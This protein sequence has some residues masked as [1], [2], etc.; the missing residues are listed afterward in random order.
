MI[1]L[2]KQSK[3]IYAYVFLLSLCVTLLAR[4]FSINANEE[5][6][7]IVRECPLE[8]AKARTLFT[9]ITN[10]RAD[11]NIERGPAS[12]ECIEKAPLEI[13]KMKER[14]WDTGVI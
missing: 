4:M 7:I 10:V 1:T 3:N 8:T 6:L 9:N 13:S 5:K 12:G 14:I 2:R 11:I